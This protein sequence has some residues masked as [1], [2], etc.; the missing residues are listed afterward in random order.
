MAISMIDFVNQTQ[1]KMRK[2]LVQ[3]I[4]NDAIFP[5]LLNFIPV[6]GM[7]YKYGEQ[8]TLGGIAFR[9]LNEQYSADTGVVNPRTEHMA[10]FGG[11]VN[12]DHQLVNKQGDVAR[13]NAILAKT[14]KAGLFFDKYVIDGDSAT[15]AKQFDG[16]NRRLTGNQ[17]IA[18]G[19]DG[20]A[21]SLSMVDDLIDR[22]VGPNNRK[23]LVMCKQDRRKLKQLAIVAAGGAQLT[24][25]GGSYGAYDGVKIEVLDED[26]DEQ[27]I[28]A[29][30]EAQGENGETSS[31]YCIMPGADADGEFMQGLVGSKM[32]E[33]YQ[34][35]M[36]GNMHVDIVE[37]HMGIALFHGRAAARLKGIS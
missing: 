31:I 33:H 19:A 34:S 37:A 25:V 32:M 15:D 11:Q 21:L 16:L 10:L 24:D 8:T 13:S 6:D 5:R 1:D 18:A 23:I 12:T 27:P 7:E 36:S 29:K 35:G 20:A 26:G 9:S 30:D 14:R 17:V 2:G 28:L 4:T 3:K 22:V